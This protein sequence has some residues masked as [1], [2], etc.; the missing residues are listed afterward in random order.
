MTIFS[1]VIEGIKLARDL[2]EFHERN[3]QRAHH[4][5]IDRRKEIARQRALIDREVTKRTDLP[6]E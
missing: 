5:I 3:T 1:L 4:D 2:Y 6:P